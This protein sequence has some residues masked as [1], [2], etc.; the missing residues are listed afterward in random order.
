M[1][2]FKCRKILHVQFF[3]VILSFVML[4]FVDIN[5]FNIDGLNFA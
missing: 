4:Y 5:R 3:I 2:T 1:Y